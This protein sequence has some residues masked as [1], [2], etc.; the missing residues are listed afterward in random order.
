MIALSATV[1]SNICRLAEVIMLE[2]H[3]AAK[4]NP[5]PAT[6]AI[7]GVSFL[8][9]TLDPREVSETLRVS[10]WPA[11]RIILAPMAIHI[12]MLSR[13]CG[14]RLLPLNRIQVFMRSRDIPDNGAETMH[15]VLFS[16]VQN[17]LNLAYD[18]PATAEPLSFFPCSRLS[19]TVASANVVV[20]PSF[21]LPSAILRSIRLMIFPLRVFGRA[22]AN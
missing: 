13:R 7:N 15:A 4:K 19:T 11:I 9:W 6:D 3:L 1:R 17:L 14:I 2:D 22:S 10:R 21:S 8:P 20:S 16:F 18:F 5:R 12:L